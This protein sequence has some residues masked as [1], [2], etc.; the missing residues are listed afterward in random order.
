MNEEEYKLK[1][2]FN[3]QKVSPKEINVLLQSKRQTSNNDINIS[4]QS[5]NNRDIIFTYGNYRILKYDKNGDPLFLIGPD[6]AYF[7]FLFLLNIIY[8][9]FLS[10]VIIYLT[11][12]VL[13]IIGIILNLIQLITFIISEIKN[14]GLPKREIQN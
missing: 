7:Y 12:I 4:I 1:D 9:F 13:S 11:K 6:Y 14:P 2:D 8:F 3:I 5:I 10:G